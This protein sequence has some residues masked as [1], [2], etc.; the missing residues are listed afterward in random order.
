MIFTKDFSKKKLEKK[1]K[2]IKWLFWVL[3]S[4]DADIKDLDGCGNPGHDKVI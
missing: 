4:H 2:Y 3:K 1:Q